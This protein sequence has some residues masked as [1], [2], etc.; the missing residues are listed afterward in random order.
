[1]PRQRPVAG[2]RNRNR[3]GSSPAPEAPIP[4]QPT[5]Q[6]PTAQQPT[7]E[8]PAVAPARR[9]AVLDRAQT[10]P[11]APTAPSATPA[12][13]GRR[14]S[15]GDLLVLVAA[16]LTLAL[17]LTAGLLAVRAGGED[18]VEQARTSALAAAESHAVDL[19]SYDYRHLDRDFARARKALTGSFADDYTKTTTS[20]IKPTAEEVKAVVTADVAASSVV[21]ADQ[22]RVVVLLYV[23][24]TTTSTRLDGPKVDLNRVRLT[25]D[26]VDGE[27]LVSKVVAL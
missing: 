13:A 9:T 4:E 15:R 12:P 3:L 5:A 16:L 11:S 18:R 6:Q 7:D 25:L 27:W 26:R 21:Q 14:G 24:Q 23:N 10:A 2:Q 17:L 19:L 22:N 20:V 1:V 8:T